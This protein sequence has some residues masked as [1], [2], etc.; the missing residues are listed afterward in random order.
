[1]GLIPFLSLAVSAATTVTQM[2]QAGRAADAQREQNNIQGANQEIQNR[3][4][5][6]NKIK[7]ARIMRARMEAA[8]QSSNTGGS[9]GELGAS[10]ALSSSLAGSFAAQ[11]TQESAARGITRQSG[12]I[13]DAQYKSNAAAAWGNVFQ[14]GLEMANEE[15]WLKNLGK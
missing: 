2:K 4:N 14:Q 7:E 5:R 15:G 9:S 1:M 12:V 6:R 11:R 3:V 10:S 13:A 8:S